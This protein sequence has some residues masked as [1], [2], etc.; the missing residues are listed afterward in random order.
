MLKKRG[1]RGSMSQFWSEFAKAAD[2]LHT[3]VLD[4]EVRRAFDRIEAILRRSGQS[5]I[6]EVT[7]QDEKAVLAFTPEGDPAV[8]AQIDAFLSEMPQLP[9]WRVYGRRQRKPLADAFAF[10]AH[11]Y[12]L[13]LDEARF[14]PQREREGVTVTMFSDAVKDLS[15]DVARGLL[16]TFLD[17]AVGEELMMSKITRMETKTAAQLLPGRSDVLAPAQLVMALASTS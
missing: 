4:G 7:G 6:C 3:L 10:V 12:G 9:R 2:K 5:F 1:R 8:A 17:H 16:A 15:P 14:V 13:A 11:I